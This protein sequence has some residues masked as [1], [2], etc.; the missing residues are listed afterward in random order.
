MPIRWK[1][2]KLAVYLASD[3]SA[4]V[5]GSDFLIDGGSGH[6]GVGLSLVA[7]AKPEEFFLG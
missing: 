5:V 1:S 2:R 6:F 3:D 4:Y 7:R